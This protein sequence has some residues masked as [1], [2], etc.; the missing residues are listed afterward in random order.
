MT[1]GAGF[2]INNCDDLV[3]IDAEDL[4]KVSQWNWCASYRKRRDGTKYV[5]SVRCTSRRNNRIKLHK[6][7][8]DAPG[9]VDHV[10]GNP[11]D[12]RRSNLRPATASQNK[13]NTGP[14]WNK[15]TKGITRSAGKWMAQIETGGKKLFLGRFT[16]PDEAMRKYDEAATRIFGQYA[17]GNAATW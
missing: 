4:E 7:I 11:L 2:K 13:A 8:C 17:R 12:C 10:N 5:D 3:L 9:I 15:T 1:Q 6:F 16:N 14:N